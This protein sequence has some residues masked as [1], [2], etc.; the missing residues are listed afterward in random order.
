[1]DTRP[2]VPLARRPLPSEDQLRLM[3]KVAR[4]YHERG[5]RQA[6]IAAELHISQPRVSRLLKR[7]EEV[8]VVRTTVSMPPGVH[9][10]LEDALEA[11]Y[12]LG[13]AVVVDAGGGDEE[14]T[15]A[16]GAATATYL[17]ST[18]TGGDLVGISSWSA[19][20]LAAVDHLRPFRTSVV[21]TVVQ[22]VGGVGEPRVQMQAT[23]LLDRFATATGAAPVFLSAPGLLGSAE[24]RATLMADP[25]QQEAVAAWQRL[26]MVLVG[27]GSLEPS[28]LLRESGNALPDSDQ[29]ALRAAGA[30]GDICQR[31]FDAGGEP[32]ATGVDERVVGIAADA[33][34]RIERRIGVAGGLRKHSAI[35]A[36]LLGDWVNVLI[37]DVDEAERLV[38]DA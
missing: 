3:A 29:E 23:R 35:R 31:F 30:V 4:M 10:D 11:A 14:V 27:I 17:E 24:A 16:L 22:L 18:L 7:A 9:T 34:R 38:A 32:V 21:D 5:L 33:L 1:M 26:S 13:E 36:A 19:T 25:S 2:G 20:L 12:G 6:Q 37:T 15:E 8:G 28:P